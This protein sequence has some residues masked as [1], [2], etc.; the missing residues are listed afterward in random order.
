MLLRAI[1]NSPNKVF[2]YIII[3]ILIFS[4]IGAAVYFLF[5]FNKKLT[6]PPGMDPCVNGTVCCHKK[7]KCYKDRCCEPGKIC[8][9]K[10]CD[11]D[12]GNQGCCPDDKPINYMGDCCNTANACGTGCCDN[13]CCEI[14]G[15]LVCCPTGT[16]CFNGKCCPSSK[17]CGPTGA[18]GCCEHDCC[19]G[20]CCHTGT[21]CIGEST[22]C[23]LDKVCDNKFCCTGPEKCM[24]IVGTTDNICCPKNRQNKHDQCCPEGKTVVN[25]ECCLLEKQCGTGCCEYDCC[26]ED[27]KTCCKAIKPN[28]RESDKTCQ[29]TCGTELCPETAPL[30]HKGHCCATGRNCGTQD[31]CCPDDC[32]AG[33]CCPTGSPCYIGA[34]CDKDLHC[35]SSCCPTLCCKGSCCPQG[36]VCTVTDG[37]CP[38]NRACGDKCC[39]EGQTCHNGVCC[40]LA[41]ACGDQNQCCPKPCCNGNCCNDDEQC[42]GQG[43]DR[44]C[45]VPCGTEYCDPYKQTCIHTTDISGKELWS[46]KNN[47]GCRWGRID[48]DPGDMNRE[49]PNYSA[50]GCEGPLDLQICENNDGKLVYCSNPYGVEGPFSRSVTT[51]IDPSQPNCT[52]GNCYDRINECGLELVNYDYN[53]CKGNFDCKQEL[54]ACDGTCP[55]DGDKAAQCCKDTIT[56]KYTG[57]I[58]PTGQICFD[59]S[60]GQ[61]ICG[62]GWKPNKDGHPYCDPVIDSAAGVKYLTEQA[63]MTSPDMYTCP[64]GTDEENVQGALLFCGNN[65]KKCYDPVKKCEDSVWPY[66]VKL[67]NDILEFGPVGWTQP[68]N[69]AGDKWQNWQKINING[70]PVLTSARC[71]KGSVYLAAMDSNTKYCVSDSSKIPLGADAFLR[72]DGWH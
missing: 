28:C 26:G 54:P 23:S 3:G 7:M 8:S 35:G 42:H 48:Y 5:F 40:P 37:C 29:A 49:K 51:H 11:N 25:G 52:P 14:D 34:C 58:C 55:Y 20:N 69:Y 50:T 22:C 71:P 66:S 45:M 59:D 6:C 61:K 16:T 12:C 72:Y 17:A 39:P 68:A 15:K 41:Y 30:C 27:G 67:D 43:K 47:T 44:K 53:V 18:T 10:C 32:C 9:N 4:G 62:Y 65:A 63:C 2:I 38:T 60:N 19:D 70:R 21:T 13:V 33:Q 24:A 64:G 31:G 36:N 1:N 57:Q 56:G 46:C